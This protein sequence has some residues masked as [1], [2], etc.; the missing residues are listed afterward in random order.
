MDRATLVAR[1]SAGPQGCKMPWQ[2]QVLWG[3]W[4]ADA[5]AGWCVRAAEG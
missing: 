3:L 2:M 5:G 4:A 1:L